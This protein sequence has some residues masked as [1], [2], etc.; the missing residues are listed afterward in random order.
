MHFECLIGK[1]FVNDSDPDKIL[2]EIIDIYKTNFQT[3]LPESY[4]KTYNDCIGL[5]N[6]KMKGYYKCDTKYHNLV[7]TLQ[8]AI[9]ICRIMDGLNKRKNHIKI[10]EEYFGY[11]LIAALMHDTGYIKILGDDTRTGA[12]YTFKHVGRSV[13]FAQK[14]LSNNGLSKDKVTA[15]QNMIW[16]T[17]TKINIGYIR[18]SSKLERLV[19]YCLGTADVMSQMAV[20]DYIEKLPVLYNEFK[21]GY[22]YEGV[23]YLKAAGYVIFNSVEDMINRTPAFYDYW[24]KNHLMQMDSVYK[25]VTNY[26]D[27]GKNH[28]IEAIEENIRKINL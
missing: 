2:K 20:P 27:D 25:A 1:K 7:H 10:T 9:T 3:D 24:V 26:F 8:T 18:F 4:K 13:K 16:C 5:Y 23:E 21:E 19:S 15:I 11:G 28:Y 17:C 12:K 14:H 6:G 22:A